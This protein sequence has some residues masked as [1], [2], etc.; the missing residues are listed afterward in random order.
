MEDDTMQLD[1]LI[2]DIEIVKKPH[3]EQKIDRQLMVSNYVYVCKCGFKTN[4]NVRSCEH[5]LK[6]GHDVDEV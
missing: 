2:G 5:A 6:T 1:D 3:P 4:S